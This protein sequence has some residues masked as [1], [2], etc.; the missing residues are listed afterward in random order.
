MGEFY[1]GLLKTIALGL[2]YGPGMPIVYFI[3]LAAIIITY[4]STKYCLLR[5]CRQPPALDEG[6]SER[7]R[8]SLSY[9]LLFTAIL[10]L[11]VFDT[12][13]PEG[14]RSNDEQL[15]GVQL[16]PI[17]AIVLWIIHKVSPVWMLPCFAK[18]F[19]VKSND[20][21]GRPFSSEQGLPR[22]HCPISQPVPSLADSQAHTVEACVAADMATAS[23]TASAPDAGAGGT[24]FSSSDS[25]GSPASAQPLPIAQAYL[26]PQ[27][28]MMRA[29]TLLRLVCPENAGPGA[30]LIV[31]APNG[32]LVTVTVPNTTYPGSVFYVHA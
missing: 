28:A 25:K 9:V 1:A 5:V 15:S 21:G 13:L 20:T 23:S 24:H 4:W 29:P 27:P 17:M 11:F 32:E 16:Y 30:Q 18:Y 8:E 14:E 31:Q 2:F 12:R 7:F 19:D 3:T 26:A 6:I 10:Q 22:Y